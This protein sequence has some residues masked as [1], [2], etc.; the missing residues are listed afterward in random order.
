MFCR[1]CGKEI[2]E[3]M[4][5][6]PHCGM[7]SLEGSKFCSGCGAET[8]PEAEFCVKCGKK[9]AKAGVEEVSVEPAPAAAA[10]EIPEKPLPE[11]R[12]GE[13]SEKSR[14]AATLLAFF[15]GQLGI[16]RFYLGKTGT[17]VVMLIL[18]V[19]GW[20]TVWFGI[21][22][23]F[24]IPVGIWALVDFIL[25]VAGAMRDKEAKPIKNW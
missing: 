14:L 5:V 6:C 23:I 13:V 17:A 21:G 15:L 1:T 2:D 4:N 24:L 18:G 20:A 22:L 25:A 19:L 8:K 3:T 10:G 12:T 9:L 7:E 16:H 11:A